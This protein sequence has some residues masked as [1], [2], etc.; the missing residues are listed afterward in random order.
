MPNIV[1]G[2]ISFSDGQSPQAALPVKAYHI[3]QANG[4]VTEK[5][6]ATGTCNAAGEYSLSYTA[7]VPYTHLMVRAFATNGTTALAESPVYYKTTAASKEVNLTIPAGTSL[8]VTEVAALRSLVQPL[9]GTMTL[10]NY[11]DK[12]LSVLCEANGLPYDRVRMLSFADKYAA[13]NAVAIGDMLYGI[14]RQGFPLTLRE[15]INR[16]V[17]AW[18]KALDSSVSRNIVGTYTT[19]LLPNIANAVAKDFVAGP[20]DQEGKLL[21]TRLRA[22]MITGATLTTAD[23]E[24]VISNYLRFEGTDDTFW[25][26]AT[27]K[28]AVGV[29]LLATAQFTVQVANMLSGYS[30]MITRLNAQ[31]KAGTIADMKALAAWDQA[32]WV[33]EL[34]A[35]NVATPTF[36]FPAVAKGT[37]VTEKVASLAANACS[38]LE[39]AYPL[40]KAIA[41]IEA[42]ANASFFPRK[43][44]MLTFLKATV[45]A[46]Y[47]LYKHN[48]NTYIT[49]NPTSTTGV[50][51]VPKLKEEMGKFQRQFRLGAPGFE[52]RTVLLL[53]SMNLHS[54]FAVAYTGPE[55]LEA[56]SKTLGM[57]GLGTTVYQN[58]MGSVN[59]VEAVRVQAQFSQ[60]EPAVIQATDWRSKIDTNWKARIASMPELFGSL[61]SCDCEHCRS[62]YG[63]AAYLADIAQFLQR[64]KASDT[65]SAWDILMKRRPDLKY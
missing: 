23:I 6:L 36:P 9:L 1:K 32:K 10:A 38:Q 46:G 64:C 61:D 40:Q 59:K 56:K 43:A 3:S 48:I 18:T 57:T 45:N 27:V 21:T 29:P 31:R 44:D 11:P 14:Y 52:V 33:T 13:S 62:V 7:E 15:W 63:P 53:R 2:K 24:K 34:T 17:S 5:Q 20:I 19:T 22:G 25:D 54:A 55:K 58:A 28:T 30:P 41:V 8:G 4:T 50:I 47:D 60:V 42:P 16:K 65:L 26:N 39:G 49:A 51:D 12:A 35:A 37:T